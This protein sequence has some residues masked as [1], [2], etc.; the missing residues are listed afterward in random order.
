MDPLSSNR[1]TNNEPPPDPFK[2]TFTP[3]SK[4]ADFTEKPNNITHNNWKPR[5]PNEPPP[6][7]QVHNYRWSTLMHQ[8]RTGKAFNIPAPEK[9]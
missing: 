1:I 2:T 6:P 4:K 3:Q 5:E 9:A 8:F 7:A